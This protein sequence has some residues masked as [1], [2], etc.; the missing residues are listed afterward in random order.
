M[1]LKAEEQLAAL[2]KEKADKEAADAVI[3]QIDALP[4]AENVTLEHQEAV[5]AARDAYSKLTDDQKKLVSRK[6]PTNWNVQRR[7]LHSYSKSR[8]R[9][10]Y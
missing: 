3:A 6:Q 4:T 5:D 8:Q 2:K 10:W 9:I 1:L 7:R